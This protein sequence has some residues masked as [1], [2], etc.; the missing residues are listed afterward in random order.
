MMEKIFEMAMN[1]GIWALLFIYLF[2]DTRQESA[3][4]EEALKN[5]FKER[6]DKF[7]SQINLFSERL[8]RITVSLDKINCDIEDLKN[9]RQNKV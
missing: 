9:C 1:Q 6:E 8:E 4:R 5:E 2:Y 7:F 3:K